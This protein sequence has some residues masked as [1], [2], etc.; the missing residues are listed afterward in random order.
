MDKLKFYSDSGNRIALETDVNTQCVGVI[1][2]DQLIATFKTSEVLELVTPKRP[3]KEP[4]TAPKRVI[5]TRDFHFD[6][7]HYLPHH[8]GK[9]AN[10]H[11]HR[12]EL[13]VYVKGRVGRDGMLMDFQLLKGIVENRVIKYLDHS[14]LNSLVSNPTAENLCEWIWNRL[15]KANF[16]K[17]HSGIN[18]AYI[19]LWETPDCSVI[20][21]GGI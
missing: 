21:T 18:L 9:C 5:L 19:Q 17:H 11:G 20:Y 3:E 14:T 8:E 16:F 6:A 10:V 1:Q 2:N 12:W 13:K 7:A 15:I 4:K